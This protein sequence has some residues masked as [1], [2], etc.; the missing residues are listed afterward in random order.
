MG[1]TRHHKIGT[2][3][4]IEG[5]NGTIDLIVREI[6][7]TQTTRTARLEVNGVPNLSEILL[8]QQTENILFENV[9]EMGM[10]KKGTTSSSLVN[11]FYS[12]PKEYNFQ[13]RQYD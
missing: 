4:H 6:G 3:M 9:I 10:A 13:Y 5:P 8:S 12:A 1:F 11:I 2:G 7:G